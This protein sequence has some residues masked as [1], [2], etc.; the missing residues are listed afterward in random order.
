MTPPPPPKTLM[1]SPP[2]CL[3]QVDHVLEEFDVA[4]LVGRHRDALRV[5]LQGRIDDLV[6]RAVVAEVDHLGA[7]R[8]QDAPHDVD[9]GVMAVE[10]RGGGDETHLVLGLVGHQLGGNAEIGHG[11]GSGDGTATS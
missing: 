1:F 11:V 6:H 9:R 5:F 10:Q 8:L 3:E 2:R 7:G 4:A